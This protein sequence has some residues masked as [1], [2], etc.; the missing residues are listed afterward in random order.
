MLSKE[1]VGK[2]FKDDNEIKEA[3]KSGEKAVAVLVEEGL[4]VRGVVLSVDKHSLGCLEAGARQ[5]GKDPIVV[6]REED[7]LD[8]MPSIP[9]AM[10]EQKNLQT[11]F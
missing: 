3:L 6:S 10:E 8:Q 5:K 1:L 2:T 4:F 11:I 7:D 9:H